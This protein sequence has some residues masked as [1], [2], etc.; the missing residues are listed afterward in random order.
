MCASGS[1][2][3]CSTRSASASVRPVSSTGQATRWRWRS[4]SLASAACS[5]STPMTTASGHSAR[6]AAAMPE[7]RPPP[8]IGT[9]TRPACGQS[10]PISSPIVPWPAITVGVVERRDQRV[11]VLAISSPV[12]ASR[13]GRPGSQITTS[14]WVARAA[15][16]FPGGAFDGITTAAG[17]P[18]SPAAQATAAAWLPLECATTPRRRVSSGSEQIAL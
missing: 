13:A 3:I 18:S 4:E 17:T 15:A 10:V 6:T 16:I 9:S 2:P 14:A 5:G 12:A 11:A 8:L 7:I 1:S